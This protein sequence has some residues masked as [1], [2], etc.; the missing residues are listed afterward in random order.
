MTYASLLQNG[1][2][3][4]KNSESQYEVSLKYFETKKVQTF[5][6]PFGLGRPG[7]VK[8]ALPALKKNEA[9][10]VLQTED[11]FITAIKESTVV[12]Q[13][14]EALVNTT[15]VEFVELPERFLLQSH[16]IH[17][18][19]K[20]SLRNFVERWGA[21]VKAMIVSLSFNSPIRD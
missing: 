16:F 12:W 9:V 8:W 14:H 13:R 19:S 20:S 5:S 17:D 1:L 10:V 4:A 11:D 2:L 18:E 15:D 7:T 21:H 6:A 3:S